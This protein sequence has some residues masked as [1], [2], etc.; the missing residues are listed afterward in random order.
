MELEDGRNTIL[1][2]GQGAKSLFNIFK[3]IMGDDENDDDGKW[4]KVAS[5]RKVTLI[6]I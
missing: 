5:M 2:S 4:G 1:C 6:V 3:S